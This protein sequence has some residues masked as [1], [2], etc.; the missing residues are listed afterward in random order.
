MVNEN[1]DG[2]RLVEV[3]SELAQCL[4]HQTSLQAH[5]A[6]AHV[7]FDFCTWCECSNRVDNKNVNRTGTN[8]HV[9][10]FKR[11]LTS[12]WLRNEELVDVDTNGLG[13]HRIHR[14]LSVDVGTN[15]SVALCF[16]NNVHR[17][18]GLTR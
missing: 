5:V 9:G 17:K 18:C 4:A 11:L 15:A 6:I 13:V 3:G 16:C 10:D 8:E 12:V 2:V 14:V 7:A 1:T